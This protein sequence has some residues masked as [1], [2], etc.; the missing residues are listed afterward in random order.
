MVGYNYV[1]VV[2]FPVAFEV[3]EIRKRGCW[4]VSSKSWAILERHC[5]QHALHL[6]CKV[7]KRHTIVC[8]MS[9]TFPTFLVHHFVMSLRETHYNLWL[10]LVMVSNLG[11]SSFSR[12]CGA[13]SVGE[14]N[15]K[16]G[17]SWWKLNWHHKRFGKLTF[18]ELDQHQSECS[19][20]GLRSEHSLWWRANTWKVSFWNLSWG[21]STL[22]NL[23]DKNQVFMFTLPPTQHHSFFRNWKFI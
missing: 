2:G 20:E 14:W 15:M 7:L 9:S 18:Q 16:F 6:F 3:T 21:N 4:F 23:F 17:L 12:N 22:I 13:A 10:L 11:I 5:I 19:D 8:I 1:Q